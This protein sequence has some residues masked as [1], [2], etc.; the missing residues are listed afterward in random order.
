MTSQKSWFSKNYVWEQLEFY[1]RNNSKKSVVIVALFNIINVDK[2]NYV[3]EEAIWGR[4]MRCNRRVRCIISMSA[5]P[6]QV[7]LEIVRSYN[8]Y[9]PQ[10]TAHNINSSVSSVTNG[11]AWALTPTLPPELL[12]RR[13]KKRS[14]GTYLW[15]S[16]YHK[17]LINGKHLKC[18]ANALLIKFLEAE[19]IISNILLINKYNAE[20]F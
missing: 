14:P 18:I 3:D 8:I 9:G 19:V 5:A 2:G 1:W 20:L 17:Y 12:K 4:W 10:L 16:F 13:V 6:R 7:A 15:I 11:G